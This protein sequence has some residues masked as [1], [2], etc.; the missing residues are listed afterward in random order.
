MEYP[1][2]DPRNTLY[3]DVDFSHLMYKRVN[4]VLLLCSKY[5]AFILEE[6]GR[7]DEQIFKEYV[8]LNLRYPPHFIHVTTV[9]EAMKILEEQQIDLVINMLSMNAFDPIEFSKSVKKV[10]PELPVVLLT[11]MSREMTLKLASEDLSSVDYI[12]SWLGH[13]DLLLAIVKLIED[14]FN[15]D[16]DV[17]E[18]GVQVILLVEDSITFYSSYL[19]NIYNIVISQSKTF[20]HE[21]LNEYQKTVR[22]RGRPKILFAN[23]YE[24]AWEMFK[25]Y[26]HNMLG[27]ISDISYPKDGVKDEF[28]GLKLCKMVREEDKTIPFLLQSTDPSNKCYADDLRAGF[29]HKNSKTLLPELRTYL[30]DHLAFGDFLFVSP[31]THIVVAR[32]ANVKE[33]QQRVMEISEEVLEFHVSRDH[34]SK[35]LKARALFRLANVFKQVRPEHF[36]SLDG[37]RQFIYDAIDAYRKNTGRGVIAKYYRGSVDDYIMLSRIGEGYIGGKARGLAFIDLLLKQ[38]KL[39]SK[40]DGVFISIPRTVVISTVYFDAFMQNNDLYDFALQSEDNAQIITRFREAELPKALL[41]NLRRYLE[42]I[43]KP[44]AVRSSSLLEDSRFQPFAGIYSTYMVPMSGKS[45]DKMERLAMAIKSVYASVYFRDSKSYMTATKNMIDE[46][47]MAV[48][49]QEVVGNE[50]DDIYMPTF[51]GVARSLNFYPINDEK[52]EDGVMELAIGLGKHVVDGTGYNLRLSPTNPKKILQLSTTD[53]ALK[54]TQKEF[55]ALAIAPKDDIDANDLED[56]SLVERSMRK[57]P[58]DPSFKPVLSSYDFGNHMI[59]DSYDG[60]GKAVV[61]F[62]HLLKF[63][64]YPLVDI[65][66]EMLQ[67]G[68]EAMNTPVEIEFAVE[69]PDKHNK[70]MRFWMLQIRPIVE[71]GLGETV[72]PEDIRHDDAMIIS[73]K[74]IGNGNITGVRDVV[75]V[76]PETFEAKNNR[77]IAKIIEKINDQF[78]Q[79][80]GYILVGPGRWGS[81]DPWLGIPVSWAQISHARVI[82]ESS[83]E[84]Y[85]I[86]PSQGT[87]FFQNITSL[88]IG[89]MTVNQHLND[90]V[91]DY[92]YLNQC[93]QVQYEDEYVRH[94]QVDEPFQILVDGRTKNAVIYKSGKSINQ[95]HILSGI[96]DDF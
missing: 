54:Q 39:H 47:K 60:T 50:Y 73:E 62:A 72:H 69:M 64:K 93:T 8:R 78:S 5:D 41:H 91:V 94:V 56:Y 66:K 9:D 53:M 46:E 52:Y 21:G 33:L 31:H 26:Q 96:A 35:W 90:G 45:K 74:A 20:T 4:K 83:L 51:S 79:D 48:V 85:N 80:M 88:Y 23:N 6:D 57:L 49:L 34:L 65:V 82:V 77:E 68:Q 12:F 22:L 11:T 15:A 70:Q 19:P 14:K 55:V 63:N 61:T 38:N 84:N 75:Y 17:M 67:I 76:K 37:V 30:M 36:P 16:Y 87:H 13:A 29:I 7:I 28:A 71:S 3:A 1:L 92:T 40:Y 25:K 18:V 10:F 81:Q 44:L 2:T 43:E 86:D 32:A 59:R 89:Y 95:S 58:K 27:I 42:Y 24:H